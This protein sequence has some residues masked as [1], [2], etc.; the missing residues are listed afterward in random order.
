M[1]IKRFQTHI[2]D[3][4]ILNEGARSRGE[5]MEEFIVAALNGD[6]EPISKFGIES[7]AGER[8]VEQMPFKPNSGQATVL[9][10][11][12][13]EVTQKWASFWDPDNVPGS[14]KTPKTDL[15]AK[16]D[17]ISLK[18]GADA[19]LM[20][21]GRNESVA[22]FY[23][24]VDLS[25]TKLD[26]FGKKIA[27]AI[28]DLAPSSIAAGP[29]R[30]EIKKGTDAL[31]V[32]ADQAHK[33][34]TKEL[35]KMFEGN[36]E[37]AYFF[38]REAMTGETKFGGNDGTCTHFLTCDFDGENVHYIPVTDE[39][40]VRK[41]ANRAKV[42]VRMKSVS[43]KKKVG[44]KKTKT[45]RYRYWS[46]VGILADK[47]TEEAETLERDGVL[48]TENVVKRLL[49]KFMNFLKKLVSKIVEHIKKGAKYALEFMGLQPEVEFVNNIDFR[50]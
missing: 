26:A 28:G 1:S 49:S 3:N 5:E 17:K 35:T 43:E 27:E 16:S 44:G 48:L 19:Q 22:T 21:G 6:D 39:A 4:Q 18:T 14:T 41:I 46:A 34:L 8:V 20:S 10:A 2:S 23:A 25:G 38:I 47:L 13:I 37:F 32:A 33:V 24:A 31:L 9:G 11:E 42:S 7:G 40:Y 50:P 36:P 29:T 45:G 15:I 30:Q 12:T